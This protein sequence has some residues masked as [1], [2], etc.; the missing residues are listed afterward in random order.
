MKHPELNLTV[1]TQSA[2]ESLTFTVERLVCAMRYRDLAEYELRLEALATLAIP[3][4]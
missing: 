2:K 3:R 4:G 1:A